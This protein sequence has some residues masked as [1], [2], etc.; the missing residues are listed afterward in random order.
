MTSIL[1]IALASVAANPHFVD[2]RTFQNFNGQLFHPCS[3]EILIAKKTRSAEVINSSP[4]SQS[5]RPTWPHGCARLLQCLGDLGGSHVLLT[6]AF[7]GDRISQ[8]AWQPGNMPLQPDRHLLWRFNFLA[9]NPAIK[10]QSVHSKPPGRRKLG[11]A[12]HPSIWPLPNETSK[13]STA[14]CV[15]G[16]PFFMMHLSFIIFP[17]E[18]GYFRPLSQKK[19]LGMPHQ[20]LMTHFLGCTVAASRTEEPPTPRETLRRRRGLGH[21]GAGGG[22]LAV[23]A[24]PVKGQWRPIWGPQDS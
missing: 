6:V 12:A 13:V 2:S 17:S 4:L 11:S 19:I 22:A 9:Y 21:L 8:T 5:E 7:L 3:Y 16:P 20:F 23:M 18:L 1:N 14:F 10:I 24:P 15:F